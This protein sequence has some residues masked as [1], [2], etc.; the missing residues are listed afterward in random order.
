M[1]IQISSHE[2]LGLGFYKSISAATPVISVDQPPHNETIVHGV[3]GWL[4]TPNPFKLVDNNEAV[5]GGGLVNANDLTDMILRLTKADIAAMLETTASH[6]RANFSER[7]F[8]DRLAGA[9]WAPRDPF[10]RTCPA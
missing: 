1:S 7:V 10:L 8:G 5:V 9:L 2:G 3:S 4:L 6:H